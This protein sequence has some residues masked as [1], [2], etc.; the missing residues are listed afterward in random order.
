MLEGN[1]NL[2]NEES[3]EESFI[4]SLPKDIE[5]KERYVEK[6][7]IQK[8][9][10]VETIAEMKMK[11]KNPDP[12]INLNIVPKNYSFNTKYEEQ[13]LQDTE[14]FIRQFQDSCPDRAEPFLIAY[15]ECGTKKLIPTYLQPVSLDYYELFEWQ[16][17]SNFIADFMRYKYLQCPIHTP[18]I[19]PSP[20]FSIKK[21]EGNSLD[22]A[23]ILYC[24]LSTSFYNVYVVQGYASL[25]VCEMDERNKSRRL[26]DEAKVSIDVSKE[27]SK[28]VP[29]YVP[30][31]R[32]LYSKY[33]E[34]MS[35]KQK[36]HDDGTSK[37]DDDSNTSS[38]STDHSI[39]S[40]REIIED[41]FQDQRVH[42][43]ILIKS[44]KNEIFSDF[45]IEPTTGERININSPDYKYVEAVWNHNN[46]W[47]NLQSKKKMPNYNIDDSELWL[48]VFPIKLNSVII[49]ESSFI[50]KDIVLPASWTVPFTISNEDFYRR[51]PD[52]TKLRCYN[53]M[54]YRRFAPFYADDGAISKIKFYSDKEYK[55][56]IKVI[57]CFK[58]RNDNLEKQIIDKKNKIIHEYFSPFRDDALKEHIYKI[59]DSNQSDEERTMI[60]YNDSRLDG[61]SKVVRDKN[62]FT[63]EYVDRDDRLCQRTTE[64]HS[65]SILKLLKD[66]VTES[67]IARIEETFS[68][69]YDILPDE[70]IY[71]KIYKIE[72]GM[73]Y[74]RFQTDNDCI[75]FSYLD[76]IKPEKKK[77]Q[78]FILNNDMWSGFQAGVGTATYKLRDLY[79]LV[80]DLID[81]EAKAIVSLTHIKEEIQKILNQ[82]K[83]EKISFKDYI[84]E[85]R[86]VESEIEEAIQEMKSKKDKGMHLDY[87][88]PYLAALGYPETLDFKSANDIYVNCVK[89]YQSTLDGRVERM[90]CQLKN[91]KNQL[92]Q[93]QKWYR[94]NQS[95]LKKQDEQDHLELIRKVNLRIT[96]IENR[97]KWL[98]NTRKEKIDQL[99]KKLKED[100]RLEKFL[101][102]SNK[103]TTL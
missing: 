47:I 76:I 29:K 87:L 2:Q 8:K 80:A 97:L 51:F 5:E 58:N 82:R 16:P 41:P 56:L 84:Y 38:N 85:K 60:F 99:E 75:T 13:L 68:R 102:D 15:N 55:S 14:K 52:G 25:E 30:K 10:I 65:I 46:F 91:E 95:D 33:D 83:Q 63:E 78:D 39:E 27:V 66:D 37:I 59:N 19:V 101:K 4:S 89:D 6:L 71:I 7:K 45:F 73:Y 22:I 32:Q 9:D 3:E 57:K 24:L 77:G 79:P 67:E 48:K 23:M 17:C 64:Y 31:L 35:L 36:N 61:L 72:D 42:F 74:V 26:F 70:D 86:K 1:S 18:I 92:E 11:D 93:Q 62:I 12:L 20:E 44:G 49:N 100:P 90:K 34:M 40:N 43:W 94:K 96:V 54:K 98:Y 69:N 88:A 21:Q 53:C 50:K 81:S 103:S 28:K